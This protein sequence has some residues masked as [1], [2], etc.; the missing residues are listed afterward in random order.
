[1]LRLGLTLLA[2]VL[3]GLPVR[4]AEAMPT[5]ADWRAAC[6]RLPLNRSL[7][8]RLPPKEVLPLATFAPLG[9]LLRDTFAMASNGPL[10]DAALWVGSPPNRS[11]FFD[12]SQHGLPAITAAR[13][14]DPSRPF[15]PFAR[16]LVLPPGSTV[17][18]QGDLHGDI[19]SLIAVL[20]R[21]NEQGWLDGFRLTGTQRHVVFLGD[22]TDRGL[23]GVEVLYTLL[24]LHL[25]NPDR[26]HLVRGNHEDVNLVARYGFLAEG[27]AKYRDQFDAAQ[28]VR[29]YDFLP[30]VLYLG[31]GTNFVQ[32][33]HG[34]ME[35]GFNPGRLLSASGT[36]RYELLGTLRQEEFLAKNPGW[37]RSEPN[38]RADAQR[39]FAD[40]TP[41]SPTT[42]TVIGFMWND[43]TVFR[44]E[45]GFAI[46]PERAFVYGQPAV[47]ALLETVSTPAA[48]VRAIL[49]GHQH[50]SAPNPLMRRLIAARGL[51]RHWQETNS[52]A[53]R[54][55]RP[56]ELAP[57]V[58]T[59]T[60][61]PLPDGS[62][63]TLNVAPDSAYGAGCNFNFASFGILQL[64]E[65]F[66]AWRLSVEPV[67]V[68]GLPRM[69]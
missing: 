19:H 51:Y 57:R 69:E 59:A 52:S 8:G 32:L 12:V 39:V 13:P 54:L 7:G 42:P 66:E 41:T 40:F 26:V 6:A 27:M 30:V 37:L 3:I 64:A 20:G 9:Q 31:S 24:R 53:A 10:A 15:E 43:F 29:V 47:T 35:P 18:L 11:T 2:G 25:A 23:Y 49:R 5:W 28:V 33:C 4:A 65:S 56:D 22:Y 44:D 67:T 61:A 17:L 46:N 50:S 60:P 55:A 16:K 68:A 1:M 21:W 48:R 14:Y 38:A 62:V 36:N 58:G 63:W 45:A 34:G